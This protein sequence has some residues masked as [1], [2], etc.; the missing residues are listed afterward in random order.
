M[1][2]RCLEIVPVQ[3]PAQAADVPLPFPIDFRF[4]YPG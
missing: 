1:L 3:T 4:L 2:E